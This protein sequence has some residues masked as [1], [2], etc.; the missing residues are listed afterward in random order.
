M[1]KKAVLLIGSPR[2]GATTSGALGEHLMS[3]LAAK[4][5]ET[6][7]HIISRSLIAKASY[8]EMLND[9]SSSD[10]VVLSYPVYIDSPPS[11]VIRWMEMVRDDGLAELEGKTFLAIGNCEDPDPR[12]LDV[13]IMIMRNFSDGNRMRWAGGLRM[14]MSCAIDGASLSSA[15]GRGRWAAMAL[16]I[17]AAALADGQTIPEEADA[18]MSRLPMRD[19]SYVSR[20]NKTWKKRAKEKGT[21]ANLMDRPFLR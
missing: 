9:V 21:R 20:T 7:S 8:D 1:M 11:N 3:L 2:D 6:R 5:I 15:G 13:S 4:G 17:V 14:P 12:K 16:D 18:L 19:L 10:I